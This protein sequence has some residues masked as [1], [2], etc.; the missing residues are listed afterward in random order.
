MELRYPKITAQDATGQLQQI[1]SYMHQLVEQLNWAFATVTVSATGNQ[2]NTPVSTGSAGMTADEAKATFN[3][4]KSLIIKSADIIEVYREKIGTMLAGEYVAQ[5][6]Y[7]TFV[8]QTNQAIEA[9]STSI[10]QFYTDMQQIITDIESVE[11]TLIEVNAH[12][13]SGLLYYDEA[14]APVYGLEIGQRTEIDGEEVFK[15]YARFTAEKLSFFSGS[16]AEVAY[17]SDKKLYITHVE[18]IGS[19]SLG[20]LVDTVLPDGSVVTK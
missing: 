5:S 7:G 2:N 16:G 8:E 13:K 11:H 19:F 9:T 15:K 12:I 3:A 14:G 18:V 1:Q 20:H 4:I 6:E 10:E 17:I